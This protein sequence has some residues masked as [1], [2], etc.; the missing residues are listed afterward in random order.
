MEDPSVWRSISAAVAKSLRSGARG[1]T[2][3]GCSLL[4]LKSSVGALQTNSMHSIGLGVSSSGPAENKQ[5]FKL[6]K[7]KQQHT[8]VQRPCN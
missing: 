3:G 5:A 1:I 4:A 7:L 8:F 2:N 6:A